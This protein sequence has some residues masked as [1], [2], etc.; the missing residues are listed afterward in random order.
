MGTQKTVA[1]QTSTVIMKGYPIVDA[2]EIM[3]MEPGRQLNLVVYLSQR[4]TAKLKK[5]LHDVSQPGSPSYQEF[6][7]REQF[8]AEF[9]PTDA[10]VLAVVAYLENAGFT[11]VRVAPNNMRVNADGTA[12]SVNAAF[13]ADMQTFNLRGRRCFA[14]ASDVTVPQL[15]GDIVQSVLGL[16][17]VETVHM[18]SRSITGNV[19]ASRFAAAKVTPRPVELPA[20]RDAGGTAEASNADAN[21]LDWYECDVDSH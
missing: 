8:K 14:N 18:M 5:Y 13:N 3:P 4:N 19:V 16:Q 12:M 15:L 21:I 20:V 7:T 6:L 2:A 1:T 10:Q 17:D 11:D 9:A